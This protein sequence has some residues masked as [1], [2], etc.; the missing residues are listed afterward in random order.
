MSILDALESSLLDEKRSIEVDEARAL[1]AL[2][3]EELPRLLSLAHEVRRRWW[4]EGVELESLIS[5]QTGGCQ[6]DCAFCS[7]SMHYDAPAQRH[8]FLPL[9]QVMAA[10]RATEESG[11]SAFC[12]V[13]AVRGPGPAPDGPGPAGDRGDP[14][15][16]RASTSTAR[17]ASSPA[18]RRRPCATPGCTTTTTTSRPAAAS[19]REI[20]TTHT[21]EE[22]AETCRLVTELG[23]KLC[24]GGILGMGE[25]WEQRLELAYELRELGPDEIPLNF[26]NPRPGTPLA[27]R[28]PLEAHD[29]LRAIAI[30]RLVFPDRIIRYAGGREL[31]LRDA[32]ALGLVAAST[33]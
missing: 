4:G 26:L 18:R 21:W 20:V 19:S 17:S 5:A 32:Q 30:F 9:D 12:I 8:A 1:V 6:E 25:T 15:R 31:V 2:P 22:R 13:V 3:S 28:R 14:R 33:G 11:A 16:D 23:I 7:Q 29:A 10:A 27:G 24:S